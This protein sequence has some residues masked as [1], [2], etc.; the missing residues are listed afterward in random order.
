MQTTDFTKADIKDQDTMF[1]LWQERGAMTDTQL[2]RAGIS[3]ESQMKNVPVV[4]ER[5]RGADLH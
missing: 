1:R 3:R 4:A 2:E 5:V